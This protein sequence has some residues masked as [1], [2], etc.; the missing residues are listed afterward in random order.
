MTANER[1]TKLMSILESA[2][3]VVNTVVI[4]NASDHECV[5]PACIK[6]EK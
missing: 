4:D 5:S 1:R 3:L 6:E 2:L